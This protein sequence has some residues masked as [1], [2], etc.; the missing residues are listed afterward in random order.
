MATPL[1]PVD[2]H[3]SYQAKS[4]SNFRE[5]DAV[6]LF[7]KVIACFSRGRGVLCCMTPGNR[8]ETKFHP[9]RPGDSN[10]RSYDFSCPES[11]VWRSR[12]V[13][14]Q[15]IACTWRWKQC[16]LFR[17]PVKPVLKQHSQITKT[18]PSS[19]ESNQHLCKF[20]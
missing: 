18:S 7:G 9:G 13:L 5:T 16:T 17:D 8:S 19:G 6:R 4:V 1:Q 2:V 3:T 20:S 10:E 11:Q 15:M 12:R 14:S